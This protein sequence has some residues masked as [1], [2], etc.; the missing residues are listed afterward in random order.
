MILDRYYI[1]RLTEKNF[2]DFVELH[3]NVFGK[4]V[5]YDSLRKKYATAHIIDGYWAFMAYEKNTSEVVASY[6]VIP[7]LFRSDND[8]ILA[9][10]SAD[11]MTAS[12]HRGKGLFGFLHAQVAQLLQEN[13]FKFI[14]GFPNQNSHLVFQNKLKWKFYG[15]LNLYIINTGRKLPI[16]KIY[17]KFPVLK[18]MHDKVVAAKISNFQSTIQASRFE[19]D[20]PIGT[21]KNSEFYKYKLTN[22]HKVLKIN[23][24]HFLVKLTDELLLGDLVVA[25]KASFYSDMKTLIRLV[26]SLGVKN[27]NFSCTPGSPIDKLFAEHYNSIKTFPIG[28]FELAHSKINYE[29]IKFKLVDLDTF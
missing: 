23:R 19:I 24:S 11:T 18:Y 29:D 22:K 28:F 12:N 17:Y 13:N 2:T 10:Q 26:A 15:N 9:A 4:K 21:A 6:G 27:I 20:K 8:Y 3:R 5:S 25:D 14:F 1:E 16:R 7:W